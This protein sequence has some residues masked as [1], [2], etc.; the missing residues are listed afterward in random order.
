M[1]EMSLQLIFALT[2]STCGR[3]LDC[4]QDILYE[5]LSA[6]PEAQIQMPRFRHEFERLNDLIRARHPLLTGVFASIDGLSLT[7][8]ESEDDELENSTY[9]G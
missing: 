5:T 7:A 4:G 1:R 6:M 8:Q 3:Y 2:P 9:N